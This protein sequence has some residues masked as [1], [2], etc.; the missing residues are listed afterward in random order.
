MWV[1]GEVGKSDMFSAVII[2][3][4]EFS[5]GMFL[6]SNMHVYYYHFKCF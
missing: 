1:S 6:K 4:I 5:F 2:C 3:I